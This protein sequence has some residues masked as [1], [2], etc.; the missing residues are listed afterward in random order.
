M[1]DADK[2]DKVRAFVAELLKKDKALTE[3][4]VKAAVA[5]GFKV[6]PRGIGAAVIR[7]VRTELGIDRP[8]AI[9]HARSLL[10]KD[11]SMEARKVIEAVSER[12][13]VRLGPPD[14]SR[15]RPHKANTGRKP[16]PAGPSAGPAEKAAPA[17][18]AARGIGDVT[19]PFQGSGAPAD[20]AT[21]FVE[22]G[23]K[24]GNLRAR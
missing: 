19:V 6:S 11:P 14:V 4:D 17:I 18:R 2:G 9:A 24:S 21:F 13:G 10:A 7:E 15:L 8:S 5:R 16:R 1:A 23:R 20:L 12:Y 3:R 22:L